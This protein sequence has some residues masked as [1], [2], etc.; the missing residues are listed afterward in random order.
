MVK[1]DRIETFIKLKQ[2]LENT[3][4]DIKAS[5]YQLA[6][7]KNPWFTEANINLAFDGICR[8][9]DS[10]V[11]LPWLE[12]YPLS[13][14]PK[15]I[16]LVMAGNIPLVG[17][18]DFLC[19]VLSGN[20]AVIKLSSQDEVLPKHIFELLININPGIQKQIKVVDR[21]SMLDGVIATGSDNT[22]RYFKK[23]FKD[24]PHIIRKN[25]I[26]IAVLDGS[27]T[28]Q[29]L[30]LLGN[31]IFSYFGLGCRN[32][33]KVYV[34]KEFDFISL[35]DSLESHK[36]IIDHNK[37]FNNYEYNKAIYLVN[38]TEHLDNGFALFTKTSALIS[39]LAVV[40]YEHYEN[41]QQLL[42]MIELNQAKIQCIVGNGGILKSNVPIGQA[43]FPKVDDYADGVD[44]MAFLS[45]L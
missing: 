39:P 10:E 35:L 21:L 19:V 36:H 6:Q 16:G 9:L 5:L 31:D 42:K 43:Q 11:M 37:Y 7:V 27:E 14:K 4:A 29:D 34:P 45:D 30:A 41:E 13:D 18:H 38:R 40:Y 32:V 20:N 2:E 24:I 28:S 26:S 25:R 3:E 23:Y 12:N 17:F 15:N 44:T 33:A 1:E 8:L 22:S